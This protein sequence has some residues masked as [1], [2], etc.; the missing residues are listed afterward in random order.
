MPPMV[1]SLIRPLTVPRLQITL[2]NNQGNN[3]NNN[4]N[5]NNNNVEGTG[6]EKEKKIEATQDNEANSVVKPV[7]TKKKK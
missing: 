2:A 1:K 7:R 3:N 6:E 4:N 5:T